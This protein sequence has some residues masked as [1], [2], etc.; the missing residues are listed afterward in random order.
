MLETSPALVNEAIDTITA[1]RED[2]AIFPVPVSAELR[3]P[4][5]AIDPL[6]E[7]ARRGASDGQ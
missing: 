3:D 7:N 6:V 4:L 1:W 2:D 5:W